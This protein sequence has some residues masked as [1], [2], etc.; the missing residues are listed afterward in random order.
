MV[1]PELLIMR[2]MG[3]T[4]LAEVAL[5]VPWAA[6]SS[7]LLVLISGRHRRQEF[8]AAPLVVAL[9]GWVAWGATFLATDWTTRVV[10]A[11]ILILPGLVF[12]LLEAL[13]V[14]PVSNTSDPLP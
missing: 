3:W 13:G 4:S 8:P 10:V 5:A 9:L 2:T 7:L 1:A 14:T 12:L 11:I 6:L